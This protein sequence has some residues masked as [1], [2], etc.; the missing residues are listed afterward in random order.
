MDFD[1]K[2]VWNVDINGHH[3]SVRREFV[4]EDNYGVGEIVSHGPWMPTLS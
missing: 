3:R 1:L 4:V 2:S